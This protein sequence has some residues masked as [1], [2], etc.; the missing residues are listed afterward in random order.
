MYHFA[1]YDDATGDVVAHGSAPSRRI[2]DMQ[3]VEYGAGKSMFHGPAKTGVH[4][5]VLGVAVE[6]ALL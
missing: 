4:R 5:I 3:T 6:I 2:A 1:I